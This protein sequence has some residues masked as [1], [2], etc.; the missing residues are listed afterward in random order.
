MVTRAQIYGL[1]S[2]KQVRRRIAAQIAQIHKR[3]DALQ[4]A[5]DADDED[6]FIEA[7]ADRFR[8][9]VRR[10]AT[11]LEDLIQHYEEEID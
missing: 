3:I 5:F 11:E 10:W 6:P 2:P 4:K 8:D 7:V 1:G 9:D